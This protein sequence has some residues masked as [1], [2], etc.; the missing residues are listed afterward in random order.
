MYWQI[1]QIIKNF[2]KKFW[3][4]FKKIKNL[5]KC[6]DNLKKMKITKNALASLSKNTENVQNLKNEK[7]EINT[8]FSKN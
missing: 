5:G 8:N 3:Q 2:E 4:I 7:F 6:V 1:F